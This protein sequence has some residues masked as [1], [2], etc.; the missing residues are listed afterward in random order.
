MFLVKT[1]RP[2]G[3]LNVDLEIESSGNL[4]LLTDEMGKAVLVLYSG[5]GSGKRRLLCLESS[6]WPNT[7][8]AAARALCSAVERLSVRARKLWDRARR[9]E[10]DVGYELRIGVRAL[11]VALQP[12]TLKRIV[13][14]G[15]T[16]AFTCYRDND[17]EANGAVNGRQRI[18]LKRNRK[19]GSG[20]P[21]WSSPPS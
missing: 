13:A 2:A 7:P 16:V 18:R 19:L 15:A 5:P 3:F 6:R 17:S 14:L 10:F 8:D 20:K 1:K 12:E 9:K 4:D 11:Q 21:A